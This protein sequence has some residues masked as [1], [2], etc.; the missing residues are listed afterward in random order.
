[1]SAE[2]FGLQHFTPIIAGS[3]AEQGRYHPA[4][5]LAMVQGDH[6]C[7]ATE[8]R[9]ARGASKAYG[10]R[11]VHAVIELLQSDVARNMARSA[12][13]ISRN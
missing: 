11:G 9:S 8:R 6:G 7:L 10:A 3:V 13:P 5:E 2:L 1:L 12:R 4:V